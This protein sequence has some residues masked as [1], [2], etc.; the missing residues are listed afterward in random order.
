[1]AE[2][3]AARERSGGRQG[4]ARSREARGD[5]SGGKIGSRRWEVRVLDAATGAGQ[6]QGHW[7]GAGVMP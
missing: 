2:Q 4:S 7:E 5:D 1:M 3:R 6:G